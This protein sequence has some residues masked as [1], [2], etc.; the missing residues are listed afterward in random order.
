MVFSSNTEQGFDFLTWGSSW[1]PVDLDGFKTMLH[2]IADE[3][4]DPSGSPPAIS[5]RSYANEYVVLDLETTGLDV[6]NSRIIEIGALLICGG[7]PSDEYH[8]FIRQDSPLS[9]KISALTGICQEDVAAG[10][11]FTDAL[12]ELSAFIAGRLVIGYNIKQYDEKILN[13]ECR[14]HGLRSP[15][16][17]TQDILL[18]ARRRFPDL[19]SHRQQA[20]AQKLGI[21]VSDSHRALSDC[22]ICYEIYRRLTAPLQT[23]KEG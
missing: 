21:T 14:R 8:K 20:V 9:E 7:A 1:I 18:M 11:E 3:I 10:A 17:K 4:S 15:L 12:H 6:R 13:Y 19:R 22:H 16:R 2:P 23:D 5:R